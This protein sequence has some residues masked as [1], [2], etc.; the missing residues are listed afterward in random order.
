[1]NGTINIALNSAYEPTMDAEVADSFFVWTSVTTMSGTPK[2]SLPELP[3]YNY[4]DT[5]RINEGILLVRFDKDKYEIYANGI[6]SLSSQETVTV[7]VVAANG[8]AMGKYNC[9]ANT[10]MV[11]LHDLQLCKGIYLLNIVSESG[12]KF[13]LKYTK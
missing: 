12:K 11:N 4:W 3:V 8:V 5:S 6:N 1:M 13:T 10:I 9:T 7:T 2:L